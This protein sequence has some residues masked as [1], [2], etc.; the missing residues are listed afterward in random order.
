ML[1][2]LKRFFRERREFQLRDRIRAAF[3]T[4]EPLSRF[5]ARDVRRQILI[6][7]ID[8]IE[9]GFVVAQTKTDNILY[10]SKK[11]AVESEF[12]APSRIQVGRMWEWTGNSWGGLPDGTSIVDR[13]QS[14][15]SDPQND[16]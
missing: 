6:V 9:S 11:L 2:S 7:N 4:G 13:V 8:E 16:G 3:E 5:I 14:A 10:L 15:P 1:Q 12:G